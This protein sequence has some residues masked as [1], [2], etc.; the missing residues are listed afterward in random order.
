MTNKLLIVEDEP[1][2]LELL[3]YN[4]RREGYEI[5]TAEDGEQ[6]LSKVNAFKPDLIILDLMLPRIDGLE[7]CRRLKS[8]NDTKLIPIIM[9]TAKSEETDVVLGLG[10]GADDYISKPFRPKEL[11]A[12][13]QSVIRRAQM[14]SEESLDERII[15]LDE[16]EIQVDQYKVFLAGE[17]V[18]L[19]LS[20]FRILTALAGQPN[21]VFSREQL[22]RETMGE[23]VVV[24]DRNVDVHIRAIRKALKDNN[25]I[26]TVRGVGY[27]FKSS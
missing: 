23:Q 3:M 10:L 1:D 4:L 13:I 15:R 6:A 7:V 24:V 5:Q 27:R 22:L 26:E 17:P 14:S 12:R 25:Y 16:L 11:L 20:E 8:N 18:T 21:R 19:T 9:L 2:I